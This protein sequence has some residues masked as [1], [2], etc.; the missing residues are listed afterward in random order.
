MMVSYDIDRNLKQILLK[1][2]MFEKRET[3][4]VWRAEQLIWV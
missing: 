3:K 4:I 1:E 2:K